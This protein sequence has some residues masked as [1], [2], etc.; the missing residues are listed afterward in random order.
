MLGAEARLSRSSQKHIGSVDPYALKIP[1]LKANAPVPLKIAAESADF[2]TCRMLS[3]I[4]RKNSTTT[5]RIGLATIMIPTLSSSKTSTRC[6]R[7][8]AAA[9]T[10][11]H[12]VGR[13]HGKQI[14]WM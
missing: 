3:E 14:P 13:Q 8:C 1:A 11:S 12:A 9:A 2:T 7:L 6:S 10:K 4:P 5:G